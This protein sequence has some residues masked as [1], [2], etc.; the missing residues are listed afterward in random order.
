MVLSG[1]LLPRLGEPRAVRPDGVCSGL[2]RVSWA[3]F[4]GRW[5]ASPTSA[6]RTHGSRALRAG[7]TRPPK[8]SST[9][10]SGC[11]EARRPTPGLRP[12]PRRAPPP[13]RRRAARRA[14]RAPPTPSTT[15]GP[16]STAPAAPPPP[17]PPPA[18]P[19][20]CRWRRCR[21]LPRSRAR[22][23]T[24]RP[25]RT[26]SSRCCTRRTAV[27]ASRASRRPTRCCSRRRAD[28]RAP[29][30]RASTLAAASFSAA[31]PPTPSV[32][33][34][35]TLATR[36]TRT[37]PP[38]PPGGGGRRGGGVAPRAHL[39]GDRAGGGRDG[40]RRRQ[41][42]RARAAARGPQVRRGG[43]E[44]R[45][46]AHGRELEPPPSS[47]DRCSATHACALLGGQPKQTTTSRRT[48]GTRS[49]CRSPPASRAPR[50]PSR[51]PSCASS[52]LSA[53]SR[54]TRRTR[55]RATSS[56]SGACGH[57]CP[58]RAPFLL[59]FWCRGEI[60]S[61]RR[62]CR[63]YEVAGLSWTMRKVGVAI[64]A[65][66]PPPPPRPASHR[67]AAP[68]DRAPPPPLLITAGGCGHLRLAAHRHV[69]RGQ[70]ALRGGRED[71]AR[72]LREEPARGRHPYPASSGPR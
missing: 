55:P 32:V 28:P 45:R 53:R 2:T 54:S 6:G 25:C 71:R 38:R 17:P 18:R 1:T 24:P 33:S 36:T 44:G 58:A 62:R 5:A 37:P 40:R 42:A 51:S 39:Q 49:W 7:D 16:A 59:L 12:S 4:L 66:P 61:A 60:H 30:L 41:G 63:Y 56:A 22:R 64:F 3:P 68:L 14:L 48:S 19:T 29:A 27:T 46:C 23:T 31:R 26:R 34:S 72:L 70:G 69:R 8:R 15:S 67:P 57:P 20:R 47:A 9:S 11:R 10:P 13:P 50:R 35:T 65:A 52:T 43:A 21:P